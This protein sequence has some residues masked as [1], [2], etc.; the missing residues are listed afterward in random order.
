MN[1]Y[2]TDLKGNNPTL[3]ILIREC[4][5]IQPKIW[6]RYD[7]G[8]EAMTPVSGLKA[9]DVLKEVEKLASSASS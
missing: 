8:K 1:K 9:E 3:P 4:S 6:A 5:G 7:F 2:Y